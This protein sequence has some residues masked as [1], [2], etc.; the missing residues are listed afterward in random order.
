MR[1][2]SPILPDCDVTLYKVACQA[3]SELFKPEGHMPY[4]LSEHYGYNKEEKSVNYFTKTV[5][6][7]SVSFDE[8]YSQATETAKSLGLEYLGPMSKGA[9]SLFY[10]NLLKEYGYTVEKINTSLFEIVHLAGTD[11][12]EIVNITS[13]I[14]KK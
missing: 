3:F 2:I 13:P 14:V 10:S 4:L 7:D 8:F 11:A 9:M 6:I 1:R 5:N 12:G